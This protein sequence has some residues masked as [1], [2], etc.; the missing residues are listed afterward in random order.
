VS[1]ASVLIVATRYDVGSYY[2]HKWAR[3]LQRDLVTMGHTCLMLDAGDL[4]RSGSSL[5]D[6]IDCVEYVVFYGH[7]QADEW[8]A[9]PP[10]SSG[11]TTALV[12]TGNV[13]ILS[14]RRVYAGCCH[15]LAKLGKDYGLVFPSGE[16]VGYDKQFA[17]ESANH[18]FFRDVVNGSVVAFV[19]GASRQVVVAGLQTAWAR[20]RD[21]FAGGGILQHQ[22]N[23]FAASKY[24][25]GN[26]IRVGYRP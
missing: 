10:G 1:A 21:A 2:T 13:Q 25:E 6:A 22:T 18:K 4:C 9:L 7:G 24:A 5:A 14:G 19:K 12:N 8:I 20:L 26:R 23:A 16:Y 3:A 15:S 17:F 11:A